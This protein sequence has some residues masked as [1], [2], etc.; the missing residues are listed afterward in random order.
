MPLLLDFKIRLK[1]FWRH[2]KNNLANLGLLWKLSLSLTSIALVFSLGSI[3]IY[4]NEDLIRGELFYSYKRS[5][6]DYLLKSKNKPE[7][8][9]AYLLTLSDR[10]L[11]EAE[12]ALAES[13]L[14]WLPVAAA[15]NKTGQIP[16]EVTDLLTI[17]LGDNIAAG[18]VYESSATLATALSTDQQKQFEKQIVAKI[19]E[20]QEKLTVLMETSTNQQFTDSTIKIVIINNLNKYL[21]TNN[22]N[23]LAPITANLTNLE[24]ENNELVKYSQQE[25]G[26]VF[27]KLNAEELDQA[28]AELDLA[29]K[30]TNVELDSLLEQF[31]YNLE[32]TISNLNQQIEATNRQM[33]AIVN[34]FNLQI[35][36]LTQEFNGLIGQA[37]E[38]L[39][40]QIETI[41][42][43]S[44]L[45]PVEKEELIEDLNEDHEDGL[46]DLEANFEDNYEDIE[47][48]FESQ[49]EDL[50]D[51]LN[52][53]TDNLESQLDD[54]LDELDTNIDSLFDQLDE[55]WDY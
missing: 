37:N 30:K 34:D 10:R 48:N 6:E 47:D 36:S 41:T 21:A 12:S 26:V 55:N 50:E 27:A 23:S 53:S 16:E 28:L 35:E 22:A 19:K 49:L 54:Q 44:N 20:Q 32:S 8:K 29:L 43:D 33:E 15:S 40:Q 42:Q 31:N 2:F 38:R 3:A 1:L 9:I 18:H 51:Q 45:S 7:E 11:M 5:M 13:R 39:S 52:N 25:I 4:H 17:N 46:E 14:S 24:Q